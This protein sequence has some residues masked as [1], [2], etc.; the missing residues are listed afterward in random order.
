MNLGRPLPADRY[1]EPE[2]PEPIFPDLKL[3]PKGEI[4]PDGFHWDGHR[5]VRNYKGSK[6]P[7]GID[8]K[9]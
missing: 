1:V 7:E 6:R 9:L 2:Q 8:S 3:S 5:I 4:I